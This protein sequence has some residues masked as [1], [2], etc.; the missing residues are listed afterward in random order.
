MMQLNEREVNALNS[1][2]TLGQ[3]V[4]MFR[5]CR[6]AMFNKSEEVSAARETNFWRGWI[7]RRENLK[8]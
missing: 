3:V 4:C 5:K 7:E 6:R 2:M 8:G 1:I